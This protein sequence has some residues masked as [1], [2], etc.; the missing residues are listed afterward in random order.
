MSRVLETEELTAGYLGNVDVL[1]GVS[2]HV[3][4]GE[5]VAILGANGAGKTTL[6]K[7]IC[8][9]LSARSG[10]VRFRGG[11]I[12]GQ[13]THKVARSG[14]VHVPE[15]RQ[16]FVAQSVA[17]NLRLGAMNASDWEERREQLLEVF[18]MLRE[19][20]DQNAGELSGGQQQMLAIARGLMSSPSLL[21]VDEP[22]LGLSPKLVDEL[23]ELLRRLRSELRIAILL[24]EQN[25][26]V[27]AGV[28]DRA[29]V[30]RLGNVVL[31][32]SASEVLGND[33]ILSAYLG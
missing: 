4:A 2:I 6:L 5:A 27:A 12:A 14:L 26:A 10:A 25:A 21:M 16:V 1:H 30:L 15:G 22:S 9:G 28:A 7:T 31:E 17:E 29:Y 11:E 20:L 32:E 18:P 13:P 8:G 23:T 24:V 3:S 19:K 33:E